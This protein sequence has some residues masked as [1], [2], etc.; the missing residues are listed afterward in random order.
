MFLGEGFD[1]VYGF[2]R[3]RAACRFRHPAIHINLCGPRVAR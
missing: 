3:Y 1:I 2:D